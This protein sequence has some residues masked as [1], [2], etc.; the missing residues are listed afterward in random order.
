MNVLHYL[1]EAW[2]GQS[3][4]KTDKFTAVDSDRFKSDTIETHT[5]TGC[6]KSALE[7]EIFQECLISTKSCWSKRKLKY[8]F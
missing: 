4:N 8:L 6:H 2:C 3:Q 7:A 5:K 1:Q